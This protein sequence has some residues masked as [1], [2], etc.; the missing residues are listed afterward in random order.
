[1]QARDFACDSALWQQSSS[2]TVAHPSLHL[3]AD[4]PI[5]GQPPCKIRGPRGAVD[6]IAAMGRTHGFLA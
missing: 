2:M 6:G 5:R 4:P 3:T 1:M